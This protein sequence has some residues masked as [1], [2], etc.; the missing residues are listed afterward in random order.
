MLHTESLRE[1]RHSADAESLKQ[2]MEKRHGS[3][4]YISLSL[5]LYLPPSL[6]LSLPLS[7]FSLSSLPLLSPCLSPL[8]LS[9]LPLPLSL[10]YSPM[11][12]LTSFSSPQPTPTPLRYVVAM[13]TSCVRIIHMLKVSLAYDIIIVS[14]SHV[15]SKT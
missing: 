13:N 4:H 15:K 12:L 14:Y 10:H 1:Q 7:L 6:T 5:P 11:W 9:S 3:S 2:L 8:S